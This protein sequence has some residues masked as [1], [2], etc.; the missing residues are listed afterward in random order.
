MSDT[1][2]TDDKLRH[3]VITNGKAVCV[4]FTRKLE[5]ERNE[6]RA[7]AENIR[8]YLCETWEPIPMLLPWEKDEL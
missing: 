6:A 2:E 8:D 5:R 4:E 7:E 1:P 3:S